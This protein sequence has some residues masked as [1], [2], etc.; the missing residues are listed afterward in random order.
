MNSLC[1]YVFK[2]G[3]GHL[4]NTRALNERLTILIMN[5][6]TSSSAE[7]YSAKVATLLVSLVECNSFLSVCTDIFS[8]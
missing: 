8:K 5:V 3:P 4:C 6:T 2:T 7:C 1:G